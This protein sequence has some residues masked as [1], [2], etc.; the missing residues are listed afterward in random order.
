MTQ[1]VLL[2]GMLA[3]V[4]GLVQG[5]A[6]MKQAP[7]ISISELDELRPAQDQE[8]AFALRASGV[9]MYVCVSPSGGSGEPRWTLRGPEAILVD[10]SGDFM[11]RHFGGPTWAAP[12]GS[13]VQGTLKAA[14]PS[15]RSGDIPWL[16]LDA[17]SSGPDTGL[18]GGVTSIQRVQTEGG[19]APATPCS[20]PT[21]RTPAEPLKVPYRALYNFYKTRL[22]LPV[23][24]G[25]WDL[26][27][28][29]PGRPC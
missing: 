28:T 1:R 20:A 2:V 11:G 29:R 5:C 6:L 22:T 18:F 16:L 24:E 12:D 13:A 25:V 19:A 3:G 4:L 8:F 17:R 15:P 27:C 21:A 14:I 23:P 10:L 26:V 9:Q 7:P